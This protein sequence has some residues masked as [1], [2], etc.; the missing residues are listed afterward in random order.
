MNRGSAA[1]VSGPTGPTPIKVCLVAIRNDEALAARFW[2]KVRKGDGCWEWQA[3]LSRKGY[4]QFK[5]SGRAQQAHRV[6]FIL[7][8]RDIPE[9][10]GLDHLCRN[11]K[12]VRPDHLEAVTNRENVIRGD[13]VPGR[14]FRKT[15]CPYG[16]ELTP[17][18]L[19]KS[20][21]Y[22]RC[23]TCHRKSCREYMRKIRSENR[24][25]QLQSK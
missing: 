19:V 18:N 14:N 12:C 21:P 8:G 16:H 11:K 2:A 25:G 24:S 15:H 9:G 20:R 3:C 1:S 7:A 22:R 6:S 23:L 17:E 4:G 5:I 13:T 10:L